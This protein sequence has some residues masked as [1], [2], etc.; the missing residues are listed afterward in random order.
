MT[1][2]D[3]GMSKDLRKVLDITRRMAAA[4]EL[5]ELLQLIIDR[6]VE[7]LGAERAS[8]FLYEPSTNELV[9][10]IAVNADGIRFPADKGIAGATIREG[11]TI[12][13]HDARADDMDVFN[14]TLVRDGGMFQTFLQEIH[15]HQIARRRGFDEISE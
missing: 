6:S 8:L 12:N 7:L 11:R 3:P 2:A 5:D 13:V 10:R 4:V 15:A 14:C 1:P 9:S